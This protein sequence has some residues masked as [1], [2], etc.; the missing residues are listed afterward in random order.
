V[1]NEQNRA[2]GLQYIAR[3]GLLT[4]VLKSCIVSPA[5][6]RAEPRAIPPQPESVRGKG[7]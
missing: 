1:V 2:H 6:I 7:G 5:S 3:Y 4:L